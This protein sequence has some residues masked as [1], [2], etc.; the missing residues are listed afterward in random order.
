MAASRIGYRQAMTYQPEEERP[1][2]LE[3]VP[4][5][6]GIS[7]ADAAERIDKDPEEQKNFTDPEPNEN[8][9][10]QGS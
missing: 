3:D 7:V 2:E 4:D 6:E 1:I 8:D 9:Q 5:E 10:S